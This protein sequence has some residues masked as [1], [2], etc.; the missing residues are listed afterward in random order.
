MTKY[1]YGVAGSNIKMI[2]DM[3]EERY[4]SFKSDR[5]RIPVSTPYCNNGIYKTKDEAL[6]VAYRKSQSELFD[7]AVEIQSLKSNLKKQKGFFA[8]TI[9]GCTIVNLVII[10]ISLFVA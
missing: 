5:S 2:K 3:S 8:G 1:Y 4:E 10:F 9:L 6:R 7:R